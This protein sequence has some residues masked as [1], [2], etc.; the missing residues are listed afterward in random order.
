MSVSTVCTIDRGTPLEG[1]GADPRSGSGVTAVPVMDE[2]RPTLPPGGLPHPSPARGAGVR[3]AELENVVT[4]VRNGQDDQFTGRPAARRPCDPTRRP[5]RRPT[6]QRRADD[7]SR[8]RERAHHRHRAIRLGSSSMGPT[9]DRNGR[10][11]RSL[12]TA[13]SAPVERSPWVSSSRRLDDVDA[14]HAAARSRCDRAAA[15]SG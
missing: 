8:L 5:G 13:S 7:L 9:E 11:N 1:A 6:A 15:A 14:G 10:S 4:V 3:P 2:G 12:R